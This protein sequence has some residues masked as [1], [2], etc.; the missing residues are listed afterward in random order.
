MMAHRVGWSR[1]YLKPRDEVT[2][3]SWTAAWLS[4]KV[5]TSDGALTDHSEQPQ[6]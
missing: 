4:G 6:P 3:E 1:K 5:V 2:F